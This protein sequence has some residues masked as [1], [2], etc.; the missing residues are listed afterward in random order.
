MELHIHVH[1]HADK[2]VIQLL[3]ELKTQNKNIMAT[4]AELTAKITELETAVNDEQ[5]EVANALAALQAEVQRLTDIIN[6]GT[7]A[8]PEQLQTAVD[9]INAIIEDVKTTIPNLPAP[10][11]TPE[12]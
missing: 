3:K 6:S 11:P 1:N 2:E 10:E 12:P 9:N 5:Q 7:G 8:T 4:I